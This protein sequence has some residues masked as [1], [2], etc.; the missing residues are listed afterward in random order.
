[1]ITSV[2]YQ[3]INPIVIVSDGYTHL[4][5]EKHDKPQYNM[6]DEGIAIVT[7]LMF[8][9]VPVVIDYC[10]LYLET[11]NTVDLCPRFCRCLNVCHCT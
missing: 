3:N 10:V 5:F 6:V 2:M 1:M 7:D 9:D 11:I 4:T 8:D